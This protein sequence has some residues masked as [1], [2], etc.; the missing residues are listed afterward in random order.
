MGWI[1]LRSRGVAGL[2]ATVVVALFTLVPIAAP[3]AS[4]A[5]GV[6]VRLG[7]VT[8]AAQ[9]LIT[10]PVRVICNGLGGTF[11]EDSLTVTVLQANGNTVSSGQTQISTGTF[12]GTGPMFVCDGV[13]VNRI[14]VKVLPAGGSGPFNP[15]AAVITVS[16]SH[17]ESTGGESAQLGPKV[18]TLVAA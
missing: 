4:A 17:D 10:V 16:A 12:F 8:V 5:T 13:T 6:R 11:N 2:A 1:H 15:G 3:S 9:I 7:T 14:R 18:I